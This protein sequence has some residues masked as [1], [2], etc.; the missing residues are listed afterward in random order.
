MWFWIVAKS[1]EPPLPPKIPVLSS[2]GSG[3]ERSAQ[4][5]GIGVL[6]P[7]C[8]NP[9]YSPRRHSVDQTSAMPHTGRHRDAS[10]VRSRGLG[11]V[12]RHCRALGSALS[13]IL[14]S[15]RCP[16]W[17]A[18]PSGYCLLT[19]VR[20]AQPGRHRTQQAGTHPRPTCRYNQPNSGTH[21][22]LHYTNG[23]SAS[24]TRSNQPPYYY[25]IPSN[26]F[27]SCAQ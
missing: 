8:Y 16:Q 5:P 1:E 11:P 22:T 15:R 4:G 13:A 26:T 12:G 2:R 24:Q 19:S 21:C 18:R 7:F 10:I 17:L 27:G 3:V 23:Q 14:H 25:S 20:P 6:F 9:E